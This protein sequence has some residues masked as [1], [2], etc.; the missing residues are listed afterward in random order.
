MTNKACKLIDID[1]DLTETRNVT[2]LK[3]SLS[4][5]RHMFS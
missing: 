1:H 5:C 3:V 4:P 2:G